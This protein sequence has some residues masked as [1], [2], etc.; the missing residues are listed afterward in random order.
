MAAHTKLCIFSNGRSHTSIETE[1]S[2]SCFGIKLET[3][4]SLNLQVGT[5]V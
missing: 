3:V 5:A 1:N 2:Q 4:L